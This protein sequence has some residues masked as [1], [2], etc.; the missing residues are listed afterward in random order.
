M[1]TDTE[2]VC[3]LGKTGSDQPVAKMT[4]MTQADAR[5]F[6]QAA[7]SLARTVALTIPHIASFE[8]TAEDDCLAE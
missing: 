8:L 3:L 4:R 1:P 5:V 2:N 7:T 6:L